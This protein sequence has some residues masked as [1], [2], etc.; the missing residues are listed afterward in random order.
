MIIVKATKDSETGVMASPQLLAD[1]GKFNQDLMAAGVMLDGG[2]QHPSS[3]GA[4][5]GLVFE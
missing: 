4:R 1:M 5:V 2:G 3:K